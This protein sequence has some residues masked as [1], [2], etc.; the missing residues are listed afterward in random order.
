MAK[1]EQVSTKPL[2]DDI[3]QPTTKKTR[4]FSEDNY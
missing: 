2:S 4:R 3:I 1:S